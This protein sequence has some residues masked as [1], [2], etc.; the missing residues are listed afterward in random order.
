MT[1]GFSL[2]GVPSAAGTHGPGQERAPAA[3]RAAGLVER[4]RERGA[5]VDDHGDLPVVPFATD[6]ANPTQQNVGRVTEV[7]SNVAERVG[8][9]LDGDGVPL[10][11]GGDCTITLGVAAAYARRH[12]DFGLMYLDGDIDVST[13]ESTT[14][15]ILDTMGMSHLLGRGVR[16]LVDI[17]PRRPL[18]AGDHVVAFGYDER[19]STPAQRTWL[20]GQGVD[21]YP[22][23]GMTDV[24]DRANRAWTGLA[25][26]AG[27]ILVHF[28]VD[29]ID[30]T[31]FPLANFPHFNEGL[32]Y[33]DAMVALRTFCSGQA[34]A[35]LVITEIN[36]DRDPDGTLIRRLIGDVVTA[37]V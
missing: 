26:R 34:F 29:V 25:E 7:A 31:D 16:A 19:E 2:L 12:P 5:T 20:A 37:L 18:M 17:G 36:P 6:P 10:I 4:L 8:A 30:S 11:I 1:A 15:G 28:D 22:A 23:N 14:A 3:L 27:P 21:C 9:L 32:A 35:G 33:D 24:P 13:P